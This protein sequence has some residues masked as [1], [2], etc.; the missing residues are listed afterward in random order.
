MGRRT[1]AE[2]QEGDVKTEAELGAVGLQAALRITG[3]PLKLG[4]GSGTGS[5]PELPEGVYLAGTL[6]SD[7]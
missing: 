3:H 5:P 1:E 7:F 2:T 4:E 6:I